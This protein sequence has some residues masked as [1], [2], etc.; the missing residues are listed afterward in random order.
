MKKTRFFYEYSFLLAVLLGWL[1]FCD[2]AMVRQI[3]VRKAE[4]QEKRNELN[5]QK[6]QEEKKTDQEVKTS[7]DTPKQ[8]AMPER[9]ET[10]K[11]T[12][13][14]SPEDAEIRVALT[15]SDFQS[16][17]HDAVT[18]S[19]DGKETVYKAGEL[20]QKEEVVS[21][22]EQKAGISILSIQRQCGIPAYK[23]RIE[24]HPREEGL[25]ILNI[26]SLEEYLKAVVPSEMP[27]TYEM[28]ALKAQAICARTYAWKQM[29]DSGL[30]EYGADVDDSVSYQ[31]YQNVSPQETTTRAVKETEGIILS[32][33]GQPVEAYYFS[34]SAG[35][36]STDE[37]WGAAHASSY[38]KSVPCEFDSEEPWSSWEVTI[39]R[40]VLEE[41]ASSV[42]GLTGK[43]K[44]AAVRKKSQSGAV[45]ELE[46]TTESGTEKLNGEYAIREFLS[47][48]DCQI[49][50]KDGS[51][52]KGGTLLPSAYFEITEQKDEGITLKG[53]GYGHG[54]GM[55]QTAADEM[56]KEGYTCEEILDYFFR[57]IQFGNIYDGNYDGK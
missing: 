17:Y 40:A 57:N 21:I 2:C 28:E 36:T 14:I 5:R 41:K 19:I 53:G 27:S 44:A 1:S 10:Q 31:V 56:A 4:L 22:P 6:M 33:N 54:V 9:T 34:T 47:P 16:I 55:S 26:L 29:Q 50:E 12:T 51:T 7:A 48:E 18:V 30:S 24:I 25:L 11:E 46:V 52:T 15:D 23:G 32:Q 13:H 8:T 45:T 37:I 35:M 38:L 49:T 20:K 3:Q 43:L 42:L 39:P